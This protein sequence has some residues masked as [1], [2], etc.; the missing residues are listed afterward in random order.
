MLP[1]HVLF[2]EE[3][4]LMYLDWHALREDREKWQKWSEKENSES[5]YI[6][7]GG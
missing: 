4:M 6:Y 5:P 1:A 7:K 3:C 2:S